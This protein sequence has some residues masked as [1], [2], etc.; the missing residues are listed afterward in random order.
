ML[1]NDDLRLLVH[2]DYDHSQGPVGLILAPPAQDPPELLS[3]HRVV[4]L[5]KVDEGCI[6]PPLLPLPR[7]DLGHQPANVR[8]SGG[9][10]FETGLVDPGLQ[11]VGGLCYHLG[12]DGILHNLGYMRTHHNGPDILKLCLIITL[13]LGQGH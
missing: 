12:N 11:Q 10:L 6:L 9:T 7:V 13:V 1:P 8:G 3:V 4:R 2:L 5:L